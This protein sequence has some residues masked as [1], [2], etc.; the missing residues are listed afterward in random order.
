M[1]QPDNQSVPLNL[2]TPLL[3]GFQLGILIGFFNNS[4]LTFWKLSDLQ[5]FL[6][7]E[8]T[9]HYSLPQI[10]KENV[11]NLLEDWKFDSE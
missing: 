5:L 3:A 1:L 6:E 4:F 7:S 2:A 11:Q 8:T 9:S 10:F